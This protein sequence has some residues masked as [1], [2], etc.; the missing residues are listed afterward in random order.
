MRDGATESSPR[1]RMNTP[2]S[3]AHHLSGGR[4]ALGWEFV[5]KPHA[6]CPNLSDR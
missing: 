5:V 1:G 6:W 2:D 3:N 4:P